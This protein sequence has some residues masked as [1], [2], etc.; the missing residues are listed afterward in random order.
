MANIVISETFSLNTKLSLN[1]ITN[2]IVKIFLSVFR[3]LVS[4]NR[5][6]VDSAIIFFESDLCDSYAACLG[7]SGE[8]MCRVAQSILRGGMKPPTYQNR[9][10]V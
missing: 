3:D 8:Q 4:K 9:S 7:Y 5:V 2:I 6:Y 1:P 10:V